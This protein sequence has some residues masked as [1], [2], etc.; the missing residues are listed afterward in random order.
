MVSVVAKL[1]ARLK[2]NVIP[3]TAKTEVA[4]VSSKDEK[5]ISE[6]KELKKELDLA[7]RHFDFQ[8]NFDLIDADIYHINS[9]EARY[10]YLIKIA[11]RNRVD[12]FSST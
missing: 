3:F 1:G 2:C 12:A 8:V 5:L 11:K 9:L 10:S 7:R 6:I 4:E